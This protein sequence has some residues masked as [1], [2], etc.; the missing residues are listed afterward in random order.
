MYAMPTVPLGIGQTAE[1]IPAG[2]RGYWAGEIGVSYAEGG[3]RHR[4]HAVKVPS[5][6]GQGATSRGRT[7]NLCRGSQI[8]RGP[9]SA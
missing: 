2:G 9:P 6:Q 3:P 4:P 5:R 8:R 1:V 7:L